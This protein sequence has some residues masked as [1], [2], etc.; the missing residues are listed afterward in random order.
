MK[1]RH[2]RQYVWFDHFFPSIKLQT[3]PSNIAIG[4]GKSATKKDSDIFS[5]DHDGTYHQYLVMLGKYME[6]HHDGYLSGIV[7]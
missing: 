3:N 1:N 2:L 5:I 6:Y 7:G 4:H